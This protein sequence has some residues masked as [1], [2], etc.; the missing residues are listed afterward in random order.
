MLEG[1]KPLVSIVTACFNEQANVAELYERVRAALHAEGQ[2]FELIFVDDGSRDRTFSELCRLSRE[3]S[4]V[5]AVRLVRH[6]GH[7]AALTAGLRL[8]RG[9][10]VITMDADLQHPPEV[11][12]QLIRAWHDAFDIVYA[13]RDSSAEPGICKI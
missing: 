2:D 13:I 12:P 7:Q 11:L 10:A 8:A 9:A 6:F 4:S 1:Q 3:D 5:R